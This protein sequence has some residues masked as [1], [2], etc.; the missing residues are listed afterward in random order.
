MC[1]TVICILLGTLSK[2][3]IQ[4]KNHNKLNR[5]INSEDMQSNIEHE[6]LQK[7]IKN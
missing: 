5:S 1:V 6:Y 4:K 2:C 3:R 7:L